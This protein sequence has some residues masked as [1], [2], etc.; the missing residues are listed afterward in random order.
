MTAVHVT[1]TTLPS[2][3]GQGTANPT[4]YY[5]VC[6]LRFGD[7]VGYFDAIPIVGGPQWLAVP[8]GATRCGYAVKGG[9]VISF[10]EVIGG[11]PPFGSTGALSS[12]SD[13]A[14]TSV[15]DAQ[16]LAYQASSA[17]WINSTPSGGSG[18][19]SL[20]YQEAVLASDVAMSTGSTF[21]T[22]VSLSLAA[23]TWLLYGQAQ[24]LNANASPRI[25]LARINAG[26]TIYTQTEQTVLQGGSPG[27]NALHA[28]AVL[29]GTTTVTLQGA[30]WS[31]ADGIIKA[32][33]VVMSGGTVNT[34]LLAV[35]IA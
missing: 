25:F 3:Y 33:S 5:D 1:V 32:A 12:L 35:K 22:A 30:M 23:G 16:V 6:L 21:F 4:N 15:A 17:K 18:S 29:S 31:V 7:A 14:L 2:R 10:A 13:V 19:G 20:T 27:I 8:S 9:A 28:P 34:R 24:C 26:S 11:T